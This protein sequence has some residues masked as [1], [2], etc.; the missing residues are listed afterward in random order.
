MAFKLI[1]LI[2]VSSIW[3]IFGS[4][5]FYRSTWGPEKF[6]Q[7]K[8]TLEELGT[9]K[10]KIKHEKNVVYFKLSGIKQVFG[11]FTDDGFSQESLLSKTKIG[12][13]MTVYYN[14]YLL[15][16]D[17]PINLYVAYLADQDTVFMDYRTLNKKYFRIGV[18]LYLIDLIFSALTFWYYRK[19]NR[20]QSLSKAY[21][22]L[23]TIA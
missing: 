21:Q 15:T 3:F 2:A 22:D 20:R 5:F 16:A 6:Q 12:D 13:T 4:L 1:I 11:I 7:H 8:G 10:V 19:Y 9:T 17:K 23:Y 14:D 18:I